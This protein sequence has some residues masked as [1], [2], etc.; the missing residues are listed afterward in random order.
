MVYTIIL[1][2]G[3]LI[4]FLIYKVI[5]TSPGNPRGFAKSIAKTQ[6]NSLSAIK[7]KYPNLSK[8]K[9]YYNAMITRPGYTDETIKGIIKNAK[10]TAKEEEYSLKFKVRSGIKIKKI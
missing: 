6:L 5:K 8:E 2:I 1:I 4:L 9:Q 10:E 7:G 3:L